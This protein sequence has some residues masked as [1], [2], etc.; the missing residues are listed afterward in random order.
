MIHVPRNRVTVP[1]FFEFDA[2]AEEQARSQRFFAKRGA[3]KRAQRRYAFREKVWESARDPLWKRFR[4]KCAYCE[5][6]VK[7]STFVVDHF[8]PTGNAK[9]LDGTS[10]RDHYW[11]LAYEWSNLYVACAECQ[12]A[13]AT[14]FPIVRG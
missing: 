2:V 13:K 1:R 6:G 11:W 9:D 7:R 10:A 14:L 4:H 12:R 5:V 3:A 8:R